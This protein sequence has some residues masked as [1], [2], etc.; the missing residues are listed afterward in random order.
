MAP[1][2]LMINGYQRMMFGA[3]AVVDFVL[4]CPATTPLET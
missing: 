1:Y 3:V 4:R 2:G